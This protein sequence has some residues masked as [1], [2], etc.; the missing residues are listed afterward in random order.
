MSL[1]PVSSTLVSSTFKFVMDEFLTS[2]KKKSSKFKKLNLNIEDSYRKA[3]L[4]ENVKTI[5]QI[6]KPVNLHNFYYPS[7]LILDNKQHTFTSLKDFPPEIKCVIQGTAGQG[8][9][10]F[11]RYLS[12]IEIRNGDSIPLF[13]ELR[14][15]S[16]KKTLEQ[17]VIDA[18]IDIGIDTDRSNL[19]LVLSS[20]KISLLLDAF[21][22]ISEE[23]IKDTITF[24]EQVCCKHHYLRVIVSSRPDST[25]Q[26]S[27]QFNVYKL[28]PIGPSD[29]RPML[30]KFFDGESQSVDEIITSI[31]KSTSKIKN[32]ITTPLLLTLLTITYRGYNKIPESP[33]EF[34]EGLF[35]LLVHRHDATKPGFVRKY[36]SGLNENQLEKLFHA[37]SFCCMITQKVSLTRSETIEHIGRAIK[38]SEI[39]PCSESSFISD[40]VKNTCLIIEEG[41]DFHFIHK[42]IR[43]Y[44]AARFIRDADLDLKKKFYNAAIS[45]YVKYKE[46]VKY[47]KEIDTYC[48]DEYF[49]VKK[50]KSILDYLKWDGHSIDLTYSFGHEC[51]MHFPKADSQSNYSFNGF[52]IRANTPFSGCFE[53]LD[54]SSLGNSSNFKE[55][56]IEFI[57]NITILDKPENQSSI[58]NISN[59]H[60]SRKTDEIIHIVQL[61]TMNTKLFELIEKH[62]TEKCKDIDLQLRKIEKII[63]ERKASISMISF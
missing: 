12:S 3:S 60:L 6:D 52:L 58:E 34:Y 62:I 10:I 45:E 30:E 47:L 42:S 38:V 7:R 36:R 48:F 20:G 28:A 46:E 59:N 31:H 9:S 53:T 40:C 61:K 11:L 15:I 32:L 27:N 63:E 13:V 44:H 43:E 1:D 26:A 21:D 18:L 56:A 4:V 22:E 19:D 2:L 39:T 16:D 37:F 57:N 8:K 51:V 29:F 24:I 14:K 17:L 23:Y 50:L 55:I 54:L 35:P 49:L 33:H 41:N 5:W 25:I